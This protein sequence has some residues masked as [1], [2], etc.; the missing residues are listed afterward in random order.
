MI[1]HLNKVTPA[2]HVLVLN[3]YF[4]VKMETLVLKFV[5]T[6]ITVIRKLKYLLNA[7]V[8]VK[9]VKLIAQNAQLVLNLIS[10]IKIKI[11]AYKFA[12]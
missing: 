2:H 3:F 4:K 5:Q 1:V 6:V 9:N 11:F 8:I 7:A 10:W 12:Q